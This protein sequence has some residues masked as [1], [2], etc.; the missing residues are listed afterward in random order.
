MQAQYVFQHDDGVV[1]H[2]PDGQCEPEQRDIVDTVAQHIHRAK[3]GDQR[4]RHGKTRNDGRRQVPGEKIDDRDHQPDGEKQRELHIRN[5]VRD[6]GRGVVHDVDV[7]RGRQLLAK[8]RQLGLDGIHH[9]D[10][11]G[12]R[13]TL[14]GEDDGLFTIKP[15]AGIGVVDT[16]GDIGYVAEMNGCAIIRR[17]DQ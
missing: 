17:H 15:A 6:G 3:G 2:K 13:L 8:R 9:V 10:G 1:H 4:Q 5:R 11:V 16:V 7:D 12:V 14:H